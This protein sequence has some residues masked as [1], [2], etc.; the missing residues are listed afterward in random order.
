MKQ[1]QVLSSH[2]KTVNTPEL[3]YVPL[4]ELYYLKDIQ[5]D[6]YKS[7]TGTFEDVIMEDGFMDVIKVFPRDKKGYKIAEATHR[8]RALKNIFQN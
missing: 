7:Q 1:P 8:V 5:R 3:S 6:E 2:H 4:S